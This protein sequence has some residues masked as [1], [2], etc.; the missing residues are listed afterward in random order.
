MASTN[1]RK[2]R[3]TSSAVR[4]NRPSRRGENRGHVQGVRLKTV[5]P[6]LALFEKLKIDRQRAGI[7]VFGSQGSEDVSIGAQPH[8][9]RRCPRTLHCETSDHPRLSRIGVGQ[10]PDFLARQLFELCDRR[11]RHKDDVVLQD[12]IPPPYA[13]GVYG[14]C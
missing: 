4:R 6:V 7:D 14:Y 2:T 10:D 3:K 9:S 11:L 1:P 8:I 12:G 13:C 5:P